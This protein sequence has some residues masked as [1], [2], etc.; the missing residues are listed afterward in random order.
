MHIPKCSGTYV[1][2]ALQSAAELN[3]SEIVF[4]EL[5]W[6]FNALVK[7]SHVTLS[8]ISALK[9]EFLESLKSTEIF[10]LLR[11]PTVRFLSSVLQ[12]QKEF[13]KSTILLDREPVS[14]A[15]R[16]LDRLYEGD[17]SDESK[18]KG[19]RPPLV[20]F[21]KQIDYVFFEG[22]VL[23]RSLGDS[24]NPD[25]L[26]TEMLE[27]ISASTDWKRPELPTVNGSNSI[28]AEFD[29]I[30][31][32]LQDKD[33][34]GSLGGL[35]RRLDSAIGG[36]VQKRLLDHRRVLESEIASNSALSERIHDFYRDDYELFSRT[37]F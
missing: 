2:S 36:A 31:K 10:A 23:T 18:S 33:I 29:R 15:H 21:R 25:P 32:Y 7:P 5:P 16:I 27:A 20:H 37:N 19:R 8:Q 14:L 3:D 1:K 30:S 13:G 11:E 4:S 9:P 26:I 12:Y 22:R 6:E 34:T 28:S 24:S 35:S 17:F